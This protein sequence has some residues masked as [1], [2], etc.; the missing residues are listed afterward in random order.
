MPHLAAGMVEAV[1]WREHVLR[2]EKRI[3]L[4]QF[5]RV[6]VEWGRYAG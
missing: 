4:L 3:D 5:E 2:G 6:N 1:R